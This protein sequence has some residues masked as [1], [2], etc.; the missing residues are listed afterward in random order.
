MDKILNIGIIGM[1]STSQM[2]IKYC[3]SDL[4]NNVKIKA[5]ADINGEKLN[6]WTKAN[7]SLQYEP[8]LYTDY[9]Q[10]LEKED[11]DAVIICAPD[12]MHK[13]IALDA[14]GKGCHIL[15][16]K[17]M[18]TTIEDCLQI[19][20]ESIK[21]GKV[22]RMGFNLR[23]YP[24]YK[25]LKDVVDSGI[26]G[27]IATIEAKEL[28]HY[29]HGASFMRRW[30][31]L[32][33]NSGGFL[34]TKGC[35]DLDLINWIV[36]STPRYVSAFGG[37]HHF[38]SKDGA[39]ENCRECVLKYDCKFF[40]EF[41]PANTANTLQDAC[42][43]NVEKDIVDHE[44]ICFE[45]ENGVTASFTIHM[46]SPEYAK[47]IIICGTEAVVYADYAKSV[48]EVKRIAPKNEEVYRVDCQTKEKFGDA[49]EYRYL[50]ENFIDSIRNNEIA[51]MNDAK[52]G[53][54]ASLI[55]LSGEASM[56]LK[57]IIDI[58]D[59]PCLEG[60]EEK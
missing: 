43:F 9:K 20:D 17:P 47:N 46:L 29:K 23:Y 3:C 13:D 35:H 14:L 1:G 2:Y 59:F 18:A 45:Y 41:D 19:Y 24:F 25:K 30:H 15:L 52:A 38:N 51:G 36:G 4:R 55:A 42:V 49:G 32:K 57:K 40:M 6:A 27:S 22:V 16:E 37:R 33:K 54:Y 11:L 48:I 8:V 26:L 44:T 34:N 7:F 31:R 39:A 12:F 50:Y 58:K 28:L 56:E 5:M 10:M 60:C 53:L 21:S